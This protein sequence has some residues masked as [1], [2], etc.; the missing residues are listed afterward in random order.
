M[1]D[2]AMARSRMRLEL[3]YAGSLAGSSGYTPAVPGLYTG[4][5]AP[6]GTSVY[7]P[8]TATMQYHDT[9]GATWRD[10]LLYVQ[11]GYLD[12]A[13]LVLHGISDGANF[14]IYNNYAASLNIVLMRYGY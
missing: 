8:N 3:Y 10:A 9:A 2:V 5:Q 1:P 14:R 6:G 13:T 7:T 4:G 11:S 12:K